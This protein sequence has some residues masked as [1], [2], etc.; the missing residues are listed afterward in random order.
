MTLSPHVRGS[1][2]RIIETGKKNKRNVLEYVSEWDSDKSAARYF[3]A[4]KRMLEKKWTRCDAIRNSAQ[5]FAGTGDPGYFVTR[6][7]GRLVTS[8]EGIPEQ[9]D[10]RAILSGN[11]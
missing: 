4:Y 5:I 9:E 1:Q 3:S 2:F 6:V 10:W 7:K 8:I 11:D